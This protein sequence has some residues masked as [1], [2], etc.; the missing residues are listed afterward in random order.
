MD[1]SVGHSDMLSSASS[2]VQLRPT[3]PVESLACQTRCCQK[4]SY[5]E[6]VRGN[7]CWKKAKFTAASG[8]GK[9][10]RIGILPACLVPCHGNLSMRAHEV[11]NRHPATSRL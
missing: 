1:F 8:K 5:K 2:T 6:D 3:V 10:G 4:R 9:D 11:W 7:E